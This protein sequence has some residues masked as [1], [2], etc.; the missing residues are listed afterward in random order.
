M[1]SF[2]LLW[3][4]RKLLPKPEIE[5]ELLPTC[6]QSEKELEGLPCLYASMG[7]DTWST[8][9]DLL[10]IIKEKVWEEQQKTIWIEEEQ[11]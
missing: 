6:R 4:C 10:R 8:I 11:L 3:P 9:E 1:S 2:C 7:A 5:D